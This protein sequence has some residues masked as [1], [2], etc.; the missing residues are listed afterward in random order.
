MNKIFEFFTFMWRLIKAIIIAYI[1]NPIRRFY[2]FYI[3][4]T[5]IPDNPRNQELLDYLIDV[6]KD[7]K[8]EPQTPAQ[9]FFENQVREDW[10]N[11]FK[12]DPEDKWEDN[13]Q[14]LYTQLAEEMF[15]YKWINEREYFDDEY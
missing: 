6:A 10:E 7:P 5:Y 12:D 2:N 15:S 11:T 13:R 3:R 4:Y 8:T 14:W 1:I 9:I